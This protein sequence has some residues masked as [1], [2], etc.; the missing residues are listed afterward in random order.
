MFK[1]FSKS[2]LAM[3]TLGLILSLSACTNN[4]NTTNN[5]SK[6]NTIQTLNNQ[7]IVETGTVIA[8]RTL[9]IKPNANNSY[10]RPYGNVG[11]SASS[12]GFRGIYGSVDLATLGRL[13]KGATAAKTAQEVIVK[14]STGETV[15]I[16]QPFKE[17]FAKG[18]SVKI[19]VRNGNAQVI[20]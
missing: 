20:H 8:V 13:F 5:K 16:T 19:L 7:Q 15:A 17:S 18:D 12:G 11:V 2:I 9:K 3:V 14:K 4:A 1:P 6:P 10:G